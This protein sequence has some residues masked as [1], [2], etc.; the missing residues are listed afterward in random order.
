MSHPLFEKHRNV[1]DSALKAI[2]TRGYWTPYPEV[3]S[4]KIY[5]ETA[6]ADARAAFEAMQGRPFQLDQPGTVGQV[7]QEIS[8]Y[9][10][11]LGITYPKPNAGALIA[12][13]KAAMPAWRKAG[14]EARVGVCLEILA[15]LNAQSFLMAYA[16]MHTTGQGFAM[17]FQA[18]GPHAQ[19]RGLEATAYAY[20]EMTRTPA[21]AQWEKAAGRGEPIRLTKTYTV[22]PRG[23]GLVIGVSTFP[24]WN[25]YPAI[26]ADLAAGNPVIVKPHPAAILPLALTVRTARAVLAEAGFDP[27]LVLLAAD[28]AAAPIAKDLALRPE[29]ALIDYTGGQAF[30]DWLEKNARQAT[31]FTE[32]AG[33]NTVV[34]DST[35]DLNGMLQ[36]LAFSLSLYSGQM[37]TTPKTIFIPKRGIAA[38]SGPVSFDDVARGLAMAIDKLLADPAR[39]VEILGCI[40]N[41]ASLERIDR[42]ARDGH[43]VLATRAIA[44]PNFAAATVQTP[45]LVHVEPSREAVYMSE[46]FGP[47]TYLVPVETTEEALERAMRTHRTKGAITAAVY[48]TD[49]NVIEAAV[50]RAA[51][52]GVALSCNL[53]GGIYVN[54]AAA[55][56]DFHATGCNPAANASLTDAAFV[57][58]RFHVAQSRIPAGAA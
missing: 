14:I 11:P 19:D 10:F 24:T 49:P 13:A 51:D 32:K 34:I 15:R 21:L 52:A 37:C 31:V 27:D 38:E 18:A 26:F 33:V 54:Q 9:G 46:T 57:A 30:G 55:F 53:T 8:P 47:V 28:D 4:G 7:G 6:N 23:I 1:L 39:A 35:S 45:L 58:P 43:V 16:A 3:P 2:A 29:V 48:S 25:G 44:H 20:A 41:K 36:N 17:A 42:A 12:A 40:Q 22:V 5:G 50:D 56:S